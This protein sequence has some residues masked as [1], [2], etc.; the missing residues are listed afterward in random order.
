MNNEP[1]ALGGIILGIVQALI[2]VLVGFEIVNWTAEQTGLVLAL[3]VAVIGGVTAWQRS[4]VSPVAP[5]D[6]PSP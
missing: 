2:A 5:L 4:R 1:V 3:V 6:L